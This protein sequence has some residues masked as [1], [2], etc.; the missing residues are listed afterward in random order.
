L[1][2][3]TSSWLSRT[4]RFGCTSY[5]PGRSVVLVRHARLLSGPSW[6]SDGPVQFTGSRSSYRRSSEDLVIQLPFLTFSLFLHMLLPV[7][8]VGE[9]SDHC[10]QP[11]DLRPAI[12]SLLFAHFSD[13]LRV[14]WPF[15]LAAHLCCAIGFGINISNAPN[16]AKYFGTFLCVAGPYSATPGIVA[17]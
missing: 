12:V 9:S 15:L 4:G 1:R 5:L 7:S 3:A 17:W 14:R 13:K 2:S 11:D 16:G 10:T 8:S 6:S